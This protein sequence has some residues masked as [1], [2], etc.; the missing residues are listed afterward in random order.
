MII[1]DE[2]DLIRNESKRNLKMQNVRTCFES[3]KKQ[4]GKYKKDLSNNF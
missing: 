1:R 2:I 3:R 4:I